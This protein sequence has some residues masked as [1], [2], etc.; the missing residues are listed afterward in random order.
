MTEF[1]TDTIELDIAVIGGGIAG[2]WLINRLTQAGYDCAL[3]EKKAL[4]GEQTIASQGMIHGGMKY[5]LRGSLTKASESVADMPRYWSHCLAGRGEVDLS[6]ATVLSRHFYFWSS[7]SVASH[8]TTFFASKTLQGRIDKVDRSDYPWLL[9]HDQFK[10][11]VYQLQEIVLDIPSVVRALASNVAGRLF[12]TPDLRLQGTA[13]NQV[14]II[15]PGTQ[16][17]QYIAAKRIILCAGKGNGDLLTQL[18]LSQPAMQLRP[19]H[20]VWVKHNISEPIYGHCLGADNTPRLTLSTHRSSDGKYIW[21]LGGSLAEKGAQQSTQEVIDSAQQEL[22]RL[23]PWLHL[24]GVQWAA[25]R[26]DRAEARQRNFL[27]PDKAFAQRCRDVHNVIVAWP[28]KLTLAP[29]LA[30][31]VV[32]L[33][34]QDAVTPSRQQRWQQLDYLAAPPVAK[35]PWD[36]LF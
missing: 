19:L 34:Q 33:L 16:Q 13:D 11:Q 14:Q 3:F 24:N 28:T 4:G 6:N 12:L 21:S 26:I 2:L 10:G 1:A 30:N 8:L 31:E 5:T 17:K 36:V 32:A 27:R 23:F 35:P 20:Q 25:A 29:N 15:L 9:R 18:K 22:Q 7:D